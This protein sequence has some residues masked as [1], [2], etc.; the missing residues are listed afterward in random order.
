M[1]YYGRLLAFFIFLL[2]Y[3]GFITGAAFFRNAGLAREL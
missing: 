2:H 3:D 1:R